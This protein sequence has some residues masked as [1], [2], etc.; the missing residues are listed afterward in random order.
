MNR[1]KTWW[2]SLNGTKQAIIAIIFFVTLGAGGG[3]LFTS[4]KGLPARVTELERQHI[5]TTDKLETL[6]HKLDEA[7][8]ILKQTE[9]DNPLDC[10]D[11]D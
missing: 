6:D 7:L 4:Y 10:I 1:L 5:Q 2:T 8:C 9:G 11:G 3:S